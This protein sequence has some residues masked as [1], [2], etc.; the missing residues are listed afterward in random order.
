MK[1]SRHWEFLLLQW[2]GIFI[3]YTLRV[4][5]S[6][7]VVK[8]QPELGWSEV[9]EGLV[10][11]SF[12]WGYIAGQIPTAVALQKNWIK[13]TTIFGISI[14]VPAALTMLVPW[15][16][17][18]SFNLALAM[19]CVIGF[20]ESA[21][22]PTAYFFFRKW[23][24]ESERVVMIST[25]LS[26]SYFGEII[27]FLL[28]GWLLKEFGWPWVFYSF[29]ALGILWYPFWLMFAYENPRDHPK[30]TKADL[31]YITA[32]RYALVDDGEDQGFVT[33]EGAPKGLLNPTLKKMN[34]TDNTSSFASGLDSF[35][36]YNLVEPL[37]QTTE[38][39]NEEEDVSLV[40]TEQRLLSGEDFMQRQREQSKAAHVSISRIPWGEM[41]QSKMIWTLMFNSFCLGWTLFT[42]LSEV[43]SYLHSE[44]FGFSA[45]EAGLYSTIPFTCLFIGAIGAGYV[46]RVLERGCGFSKWQQRT[47]SVFLYMIAGPFLLLMCMFSDGKWAVFILLCGATGLTGFNTTGIGPAYLDVVPRF[48]GFVNT[49]ANSLAA[50][51]GILGPMVAS[52]LLVKY[53]DTAG[54]D[55]LFGITFILNCCGFLTWYFFAEVEINQLINTPATPKL[56]DRREKI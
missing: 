43:P 21:S 49:I 48:S 35:I 41:V 28:S 9:E 14:F 54:W 24:P 19:R 30:I 1:L 20:F 52:A 11:S 12:Y 44:K 8:M 51:A 2:A 55:Y 53:G 15:A 33:L 3:V 4:N 23:Y 39:E 26:A 31:D 32:G 7:A 45:G 13:C 16:S 46:M 56:A 29:G 18:E 40:P 34:I 38:G 25:F 47:F 5:I 10:L 27:G 22:F 17:R 42:L 6:V 37:V 50:G 36:D